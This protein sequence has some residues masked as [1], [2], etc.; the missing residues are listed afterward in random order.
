MSTEEEQEIWADTDVDDEDH[1]SNLEPE[2]PPGSQNETPSLNPISASSKVLVRWMLTFFLLLQ[3]QFHMADHMIFGFSK[4]FFLVLGRLYGPYDVISADFPTTLYMDK[5]SYKGLQNV[6][7]PV[8]KH[9]GTVWKL[10]DCIESEGTTEKAKLCSK[11]LFGSSRQECKSKLLKTVDLASKPTI[12]YP[13]MMYC[14]VDLG[15]SL[16]NLLVD[17]NGV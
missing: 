13:L 5:K 12:F 9:C 1:H 17:P 11:V 8:C 2:S 16:Q 6:R 14:Y 7:F 3:A 4:T 15:T 10:S